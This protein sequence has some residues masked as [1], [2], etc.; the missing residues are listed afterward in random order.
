MAKEGQ[1]NLILIVYQNS[2]DREKM[3]QRQ[4]AKLDGRAPRQQRYLS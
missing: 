1:V 2:K 4:N 3:L